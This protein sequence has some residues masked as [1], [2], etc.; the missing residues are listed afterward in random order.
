MKLTVPFLGLL[1]SVLCVCASP[2]YLL[3]RDVLLQPRQENVT[4]TIT[5]ATATATTTAASAADVFPTNVG[6]LGTT[7]AGV[8]PFLVTQDRIAGSLGNRPIDTRWNATDDSDGSFDIFQHL[9]NESPYF[10]S[11]LFADF[12]RKAAV[13]PETCTV[14]QLHLLHRHGA[15]YPTSY[16]TEG[17]PHF[18]AVIANLSGTA[19][20]KATGPL[21][22]LNDW[23][24]KLG[25]EVLVPVGTQQL[26]DS[27]IH[28]FYRYGALYNA[29][30]QK[31]K[32]VVRTT[33]QS[34]M[35]D[36]ARYFTLGFFGWDAPNLVNMEVVL[37]GGSGLA[38]DA[39]NNTLASYDTC[40]NSDTITVGDT[41]LRP[42]WDEIYLANATKR[43]QPHVEGLN[44]TTSLVYGMQSL[45]AYETVA[46]G[47]SNFCSLFT[48]D[49]WEGYEYDLDLQ[50]QGDYGMMSPSG[51]AQGIGYVQELLARLTN[52]TVLKPDGSDVTT[53]NTTLDNDAT[54]FPIDQPFYFDFTHDDIIVSVLTA[55]NYTQVVGDYLDPTKP[56]PERNFRLSWIT[57]FAARLAFEVV[58][59]TADKEEKVKAGR[60]LRTVLND[61][62]V[63]LDRDQGC[64]ENEH[65]LCKLDDFVKFQQKHA[66][67]AAN[68]DKACFGVNGTDFVVT[69]PVRNGTVY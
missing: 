54:L 12:Q 50:F 41:Y 37:E 55:L 35:L 27:G 16:S 63:P 18:G 13:L 53:Q 29:T 52:T 57:P 8:A 15:R 5:A 38:P 46:Q 21:G 4:T 65:G 58:D 32:P 42:V 14:S 59:C 30:T 60:Y 19:G 44:L 9:G 3:D 36:S 22:F 40:N 1:A 56:D 7:K 39:Y 67:E 17:A 24:Y 34:R 6:F 25:A 11:P 66:V 61:A 10:S 31:H 69:G 28:A 62:V 26:F 68:F 48:K 51:R 20:F 2:T 45:C 33:S 49:E 47:Y 64:K 23:S 43:L